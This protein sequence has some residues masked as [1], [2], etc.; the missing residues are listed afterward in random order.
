M[1]GFSYGELSAVSVA[2]AGL[3][4]DR[5]GQILSPFDSILPKASRIKAGSLESSS[6]YS[7]SPI[8]A[9]AT[10]DCL[11]QGGFA[12]VD[13]INELARKGNLVGIEAKF[14]SVFDDF[15]RAMRNEL[16]AQIH[17]GKNA[18]LVESN[19][20]MTCDFEEGS[21]VKQAQGWSPSLMSTNPYSH[22]GSATEGVVTVSVFDTKHAITPFDLSSKAEKYPELVY[23]AKKLLSVLAS[24]VQLI[25]DTGVLDTADDV[26][27]CWS[28]CAME[29]RYIAG[30]E[31]YQSLGR[32]AF[33]KALFDAMQ[34]FGEFSDELCYE[35]LENP[36]QLGEDDLD[37]F[38]RFTHTVDLNRSE[39]NVFLADGEVSEEAK[40]RSL[41]EWQSELGALLSQ[42]AKKDSASFGEKVKELLAQFCDIQQRVSNIAEPFKATPGYDLRSSY[43]SESY[44]SNGEATHHFALFREEAKSDHTETLMNIDA[45]LSQVCDQYMN[46][47]CDSGA[48][49]TTLPMTF[50]AFSGD[51]QA[52]AAMIYES[53]STLSAIPELFKLLNEMAWLVREIY[54]QINM[55]LNSDC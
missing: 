32:D 31:E 19:R 18:I 1:V 47:G 9:A 4:Q 52:D 26:V 17:T 20:L 12:T 50:S 46:D 28:H 40:R 33:A 34:E 16:L 5:S 2:Q 43:I 53:F 3:L 42:F 27:T 7:C 37:A 49:Y 41:Q 25:G 48:L 23:F 44:S 24:E 35:D 15:N 10:L 30:Q 36:G 6:V 38:D 54:G 8:I 51:D 13:E 45:A 29:A 21:L 39:A 55:A 22:G 14:E 11:V